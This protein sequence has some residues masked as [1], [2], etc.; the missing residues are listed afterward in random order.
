MIALDGEADEGG[1]RTGSLQR[2][3]HASDRARYGSRKVR[4]FSLRSTYGLPIKA[5]S[6]AV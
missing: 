1:T 3:V 5:A 2:D 4:A 6:F